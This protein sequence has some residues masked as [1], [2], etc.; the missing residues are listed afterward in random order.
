MKKKSSV[1]PHRSRKFLQLMTL[2]VNILQTQTTTSDHSATCHLHL[3]RHKEE[4]IQ[5]YTYRS[6]VIHITVVSLVSTNNHDHIPECRIL[7]QAPVVY[8]NGWGWNILN[9]TFVKLFQELGIGVD[10]LLFE[11]AHNTVC[12]FGGYEVPQEVSIEED[13]LD[14]HYE[15]TLIPT[16]LGDLHEGHEVHPFILC[17]F[18]E[19]TDPA[20]AMLKV[21]EGLAVE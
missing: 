21:A 13:S 14:Y 18:K 20:S 8:G 2:V 7:W 11:V 10:G 5:M 6:K 15:C 19:G 17:F 4:L 12:E 3:I 9:I 1:V 16:G